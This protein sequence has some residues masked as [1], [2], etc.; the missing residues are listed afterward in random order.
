MI[1]QRHK[2]II[3]GYILLIKENQVLLSRRYQTGYEDGNYSV[4]AG[5]MESGETIREGTA[6]EIYEEIGL[7]VNPQDLQCVHVMHRRGTDE[8]VDFFF[9]LNNWNQE[10]EN[11]EP[12]KCNDL[13]WFPLNDLP[14][15][16][17]PCFPF[18]PGP[19]G[20]NFN[21]PG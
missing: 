16:T 19:K 9:T 20:L 4:P 10:I 21:S 7:S 2:V 11:K 12:E 17:I 15:N 3:S 13:R 6:R 1:T 14:V 8:R 5:H 18:A